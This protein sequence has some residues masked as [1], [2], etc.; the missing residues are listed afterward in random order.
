MFHENMANGWTVIR[1]LAAVLQRDQVK[2]F[3]MFQDGGEMKNTK[4]TLLY[5]S[6]NSTSITAQLLG[7]LGKDGPNIAAE[8]IQPSMT[9]KRPTP[10]SARLREQLLGS[11]ETPRSTSDPSVPPGL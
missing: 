6:N 5:E 10:C 9:R 11:F 4:G 1:S 2:K 8:N 3:T 7:M